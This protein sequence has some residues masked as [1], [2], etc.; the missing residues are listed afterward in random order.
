MA[1]PV[2]VV[3]VAGLLAAGLVGCVP[4]DGFPIFD[5]EPTAAD[6][7][8]DDFPEIE[9]D[10]YEIDSLRFVGS[11]EDVDIFVVRLDDGMPCIVVAAGPKSS[12]GCGGGGSVDLSVQGLGT[13]RLGP[14]PVYA[15]SGWT[16][17]SENVAVSDG[18]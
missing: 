6:A 10:D 18:E 9:L 13:Y 7:L 14:A 15:D 3:A 17:I 16:I 4:S 1:R 2:L 12:I 11:H 8:P 5:R